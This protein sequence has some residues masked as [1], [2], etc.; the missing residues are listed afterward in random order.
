MIKVAVLLRGQ[1]RFS[2]EGAELFKKFVIDRHP[3]VEFK[4][5]CHSWNTL[6]RRMVNDS[7]DEKSQERILPIFLDKSETI[8]MIEPWN[9]TKLVVETEADNLRLA[10]EIENKNVTKQKETFDW[11]IDYLEKNNLDLGD[12]R[13]SNWKM[14]MPIGLDIDRVFKL[15]DMLHNQELNFHLTALTRYHQIKL[16]YLTGQMFS[17]GKAF[18]LLQD[19]MEE[20]NYYPDAILCGRYDMIA[21][22]HHWPKLIKDIKDSKNVPYPVIF[23]RNVSS[24]NSKPIMDDWLFA[25]NINSFIGL[26]SDIRRRIYN[27]LTD[28]PWRMFDLFDSGPHLQ[29]QLWTKIADPSLHFVQPTMGHWDCDLLRPGCFDLASI[30]KFDR[31][32]YK[33]LSN[34]AKNY[35]YPDNP[36]A[37]TDDESFKLYDM[38]MKEFKN[39]G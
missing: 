39:D 10:T 14:Y 33:I 25:G 9:P 26:L 34:Q 32:D 20:T 17:A 19:Y 36:R 37:M 11:F 15:H 23:S 28:H 38:M 2:K 7:D 30:N 6:S 8:S 31:N 22:F 35:R 29:H 1:P 16:S 4:F 18:R 27:S 21:W 13:L 5:F 24:A 3:E 12:K